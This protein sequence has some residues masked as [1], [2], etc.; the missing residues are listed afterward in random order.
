[1]WNFLKQ[2]W[3]ANVSARS[4]GGAAAKHGIVI[5]GQKWLGPGETLRIV[6]VDL[7]GSPHRLAL[8]STKSSSQMLEL[9]PDAPC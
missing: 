1:M 2:S 6:E 9:K 7:E 5:L 3:L 8:W 4:A